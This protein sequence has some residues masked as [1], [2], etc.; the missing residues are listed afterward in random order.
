M[1]LRLM[2]E[3]AKQV[4]STILAGFNKHYTMFRAASSRAKALYEA[5]DWHGIQQLVADRIQMYDD[6]VIEAVTV[7]RQE[8]MANLLNDDVWALAKT[9]YIALL[10]NHKQPELAETFFNSVSTKL[11]DKEYYNNQFIFVKPAIST[12]Y[13]DSDPHT[14]EAF[15]PNSQGLRGCLKKILRHFDWQVPFVNEARD[16]A[17]ILRAAKAHLQE[18]W[19]L[20]ELNLHLQVLGNAFYRNKSAYIFG[21]IINGNVRYPFAF[22]IVHEN[23]DNGSSGLVVDAALFDPQQIGVLFSFARAY[24]MVDMPVPAGYVHFLQAMLP[25]R[26]EGDLYTLLGLQK[27]GKNIFYREFHQ[28]LEYSHDSFILAPG[29]KGL[30]MS[31]FTLPSFPYVFKVIKDTFGHNKDFDREYVRQKY[32]LVKRHDR[33]GRMADTLEFS[34]VAL[35]KHRCDEEL[36]QELRTLA[37]TQIEETDDLLVVKHV[38]I[39]YRLKPLNLF[40]QSAAPAAKAAAVIDYGYALKELASANIFPGD[41]LYKNF[42]MT[43]FG[44][45]IFYDYDEIEYMTDCNFR[46]IPEAPNPEYE[47]SGEVW[48]PVNKGDVFPE[49]FGPFLLGEPDVRKVFL[50]HHRDLLTPQFW[51]AKKER[52]QA[53]I[54]EDFYPYPQSVRF[55]PD[56]VQSGLMDRPDV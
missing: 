24:F 37:P 34:N 21:Q 42:G 51:Q 15:Y 3:Q 38:Y 26:S 53:G 12:E 54:L 29:V 44:R 45:V 11:L 6:R 52:L 55:K 31:V 39:E 1:G 25:M 19:P 46:A 8:V 10:V 49:E 20:G 35:P 30:V 16:I 28:H 2:N 17:N 48:Y 50:Q 22:A 43:R 23:H 56:A 40:M 41:M 32:L 4:A 18:D 9:E 7:L 5:A 14:F 33:V 36:L 47:M 13:I 27:Q